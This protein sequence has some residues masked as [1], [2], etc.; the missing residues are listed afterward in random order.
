M[1]PSPEVAEVLRRIKWR[2]AVHEAAHAV[3]GH[4]IGWQVVFIEMS[5]MDF[6][7]QHADQWAFTRCS[8]TTSRH[9]IPSRH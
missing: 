9:D 7:N 3:V 2:T 4:E 6:T 5:D 8:V 1:E